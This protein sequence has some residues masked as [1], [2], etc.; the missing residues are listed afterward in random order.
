[1]YVNP[2]GSIATLTLGASA[3][4]TRVV[5]SVAP[6]NV[7]VEPTFLYDLE[8]EGKAGLLA[9]M[10]KWVYLEQ[11]AYASY[12]RRLIPRTRALIHHGIFQIVLLNKS[13]EKLVELLLKNY[14]INYNE[15][16]TIAAALQVGADKV[17]LKR[18]MARE[19]AR[20]LG[21]EAGGFLKF[22]GEAI[23]MGII[24]YNDLKEWA[25][26]ELGGGSTFFSQA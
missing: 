23:K 14:P 18:R 1:M 5:S 17:Y 13:E 20:E 24:S 9:K 11:R 8:L 19:V 6:Q 26:R 3:L 7:V 21:I 16:L 15:A 25:A 2:L 10:Y 4:I 12:Y 22:F